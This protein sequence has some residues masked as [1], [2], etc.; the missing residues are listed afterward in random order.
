MTKKV[1]VIIPTYK[2]GDYVRSCLESVF[3]Q[4]LNKDDYEVIIVLNGPQ[5]PFMSYIKTVVQDYHADVTLLYTEEPGVSNARNI[6]INNS[7]GEYICFIDDDDVVSSD[8]LESLL[9]V[10]TPQ[11]VGLSNIYSFVNNPCERSHGFFITDFLPARKEKIEKNSAFSNRSFLSIPVAKL[12]HRDII[13][14]RRFDVRFTNGED[15]LFVRS[16]TDRIIGIKCT[17]PKTCYYVRMRIGSA[18]RKRIPRVKLLKDGYLL[19]CQYF[20]NYLRNPRGYSLWLTLA[21]VPGVIKNIIV[22]SKNK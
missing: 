18:S 11:Y 9:V 2:P 15:A 16:L 13:G 6:G 1:S 17:E 4:S 12:F 21:S 19:I 3:T 10:S 8:Y 7:R 5:E 20:K 22:L 14:D